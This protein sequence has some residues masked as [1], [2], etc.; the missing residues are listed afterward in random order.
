MKIRYFPNTDTLF[1]ELADRLSSN[2]EAVGDT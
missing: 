1:N 2:S